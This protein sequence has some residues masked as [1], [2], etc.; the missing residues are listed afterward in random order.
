MTYVIAPLHL[1]LADVGEE[2]IREV[3]LALEGIENA[4]EWPGIGL[5]FVEEGFERPAAIIVHTD[6]P[7]GS[8]QAAAIGDQLQAIAAAHGLTADAVT[9]MG[10]DEY[11]AKAYEEAVVVPR[12]HIAPD[13]AAELGVS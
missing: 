5:G 3:S 9:T 2:K 1:E 4:D 8:P 11:E 13:A 12:E 7:P 6:A 10:D